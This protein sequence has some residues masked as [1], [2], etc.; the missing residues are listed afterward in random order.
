M[1]K[2]AHTYLVSLKATGAIQ[3]V[4][5]GDAL[6]FRVSKTGKKSWYLR[7]DTLTPDGKRKQN[8]LVVG[9]FPVMG[10]KEARAEAEARKALAKTENVN[11]AQV[12]QTF[13]EVADNWFDLK[14]REWTSEKSK[15]Q[16]RGRLSANIYPILGDMPIDK[17]TVADV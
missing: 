12:A 10:L 2:I 9:D 5:V 8:I 1:Q 14:D 4:P 15:K 17:V 3:R 6:E 11:K 13:Q 7:Y 16:N